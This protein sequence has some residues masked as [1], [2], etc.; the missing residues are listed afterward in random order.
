MEKIVRDYFPSSGVAFEEC[1]IWRLLLANDLALLSS[2][3]SDLYY[4]LNQ[5]FDVSLNAGMKIS[6][7]KTE[8]MSLS[9]HPVQCYF[10]IN[11]VTLMQTDLFKYLGVI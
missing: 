1:N 11:G 4:A 7:A 10:Q 2:N 5:F 3:K 9:R 6:T 8:I